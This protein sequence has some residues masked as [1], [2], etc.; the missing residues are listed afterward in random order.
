M[1]GK[2]RRRLLYGLACSGGSVILTLVVFEAI[3][4]CVLSPEPHSLF[5]LHDDRIRSRPYVQ[6]HP[7]RG[8]A[9]KPAYDDPPYR[10][11]R[12]GFRGNEQPED[13]A[14]RF[15]II[16]PG[17]STTFGWW[18]DN[19]QD[20]PSQLM[21][22][23]AEEGG[24]VYV[25]NAGVPSYSSTQVLL[26]LKELTRRFHPDLVL[27]NIMWNDLWYSS[28][29]EWRPDLL[30]YRMPPNW[31]CVLLRHSRFLRGIMLREPK[32]DRRV[33]HFNEQALEYY[34]QNVERMILWCKS[35]GVPLAFVQPP[36][37]ADQIPE[38]GF[39]ALQ[40][41]YTKAFFI[42]LVRKYLSALGRKASE[43]GVPVINHRLSFDYPNK[44]FLFL[45]IIHPVPEGYRMM[46]EDIHSY[47]K[48]H[49]M[50]AGQR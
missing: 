30:L 29:A 48:Q 1:K 20:Y 38:G 19:G 21:D 50:S 43:H 40:T 22:C 17:E 34:T 35:R 11:N 3:A 14:D 47:L 8:F 41:K 33:D 13:L 5:S 10:I 31:V 39:T 9:L 7:I 4:P 18:V 32:A 44:H 15:L 26:Y 16:V 42:E 36:F 37:D 49:I 6:R 27:V 46:A 23:F 25:I 24:N 12:A 2:S 45:D 28:I